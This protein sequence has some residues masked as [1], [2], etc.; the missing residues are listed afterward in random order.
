MPLMAYS[1]VCVSSTAAASVGCSVGTA[2]LT[3]S[4]SPSSAAP[5]LISFS[6]SVSVDGLL[7]TPK[8]SSAS[9]SVA[10]TSFSQSGNTPLGSTEPV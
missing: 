2:S 7:Q 4:L 6:V 5:V 9:S 8:S 1:V 10:P 3:V